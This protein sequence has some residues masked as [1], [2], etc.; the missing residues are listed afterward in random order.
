MHL[1]PNTALILN[2]CLVMHVHNH[3]QRLVKEEPF[4]TGKLMNALARS[5]EVLEA[6]R[7]SLQ[8]DRRPSCLHFHHVLLTALTERDADSLFF[9]NSVM[10]DSSKAPFFSGPSL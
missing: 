4:E 8:Q 10:T 5:I 3:L 7:R 1:G 2:S 6:S 9:L